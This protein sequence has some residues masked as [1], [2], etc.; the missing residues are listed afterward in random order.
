MNHGVP[1]AARRQPER[2]LD[3]I[4]RIS[5]LRAKGTP[6]ECE[7]PYPVDPV[8]PVKKEEADGLYYGSLFL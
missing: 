3:R 7:G 2:I 6:S 4:D 8:N 5:A 1:G